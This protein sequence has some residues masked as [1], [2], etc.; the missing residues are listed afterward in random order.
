MS[1]LQTRLQAEINRGLVGR[2]F[3]V[4]V[5]GRDRKGQSRGRTACNRIVHVEGEPEGL[6]PGT[7]VT[8]EITRGLPNSLI[9]EISG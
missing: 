5:E 9:A 3:E 4:L 6:T 8:V 7:Y 1:A 2:R